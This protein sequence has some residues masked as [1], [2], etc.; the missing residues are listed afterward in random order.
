MA[1]EGAVRYRGAYPSRRRS[2]R[3]PAKS[4]AT[5]SGT[6]AALVCRIMIEKSLLSGVCGGGGAW[7][8][9]NIVSVEPEGLGLVLGLTPKGHEYDLAKVTMPKGNKWAGQVFYE[10]NKNGK[11]FHLDG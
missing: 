1:G 5:V 8:P 6:A 2:G 4:L 10:G 3:F 9:P 7:K 11:R